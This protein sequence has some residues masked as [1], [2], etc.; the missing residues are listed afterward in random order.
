M[1][2]L[3]VLGWIYDGWGVLERSHLLLWR[4]SLPLESDIGVGYSITYSVAYMRPYFYNISR[5]VVLWMR[6]AHTF[7]HSVIWID[8]YISFLED[9]F[10]SKWSLLT[11]EAIISSRARESINQ[12]FMLWHIYLPPLSLLTGW[13]YVTKPTCGG[14]RSRDRHL[15]PGLSRLRSSWRRCRG[16]CWEVSL[17]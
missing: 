5:L 14:T 6:T 7:I 2:L 12:Q 17:I 13:G 1:C 16:R 11:L 15:Y 3:F 10:K 9:E 4:N 8:W